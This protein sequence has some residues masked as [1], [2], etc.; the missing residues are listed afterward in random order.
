MR[1]LQV[2]KSGAYLH[3]TVKRLPVAFWRNLANG[4]RWQ[5]I[6]RGGGKGARAEVARRESLSDDEAICA[7]LAAGIVFRGVLSRG[8]AYEKLGV[9]R[10]QT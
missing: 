4:Y 3:E 8:K 2:G 10:R 7:S 5:P 6:L 1:E 9:L